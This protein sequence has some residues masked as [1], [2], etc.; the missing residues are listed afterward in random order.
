MNK[1]FV[2][3]GAFLLAVVLAL[4]LFWFNK[5]R[6]LEQY[7][8][9]L[10]LQTATK[11]D[12]HKL[13]I[14]DLETGKIVIFGSSELRY[15]K[16]KFIPQNYFN[17]DLQLP[18]T[19]NGDQGHQCF[20]ILSQLAAY[21]NEKVNKNARVVIFLSPGWVSPR[22]ANGTVIT[23][24][25]KYMNSSMMYQLYFKS[26][27][28]D[29]YKRLIG[30]YIHKNINKITDISFIYKYASNYPNNSDMSK[31]D[32]YFIKKIVQIISSQQST[33]KKIIYTLPNLNYNALREEAKEVAE[34]SD[35]NQF[36]ITNKKYKKHVEPGIKKGNFPFKLAKPPII[37][38][39][40]EY[41]DFLN[42]LKL[43]KRYKIKPLFVMLDIHPYIYSKNRDSMKP[44]LTA[45][46]QEIINNDY[47]YMD[48]WTYDKSKYKIGKLLD[49]WHIGELGWVEVNKKIIEH[50]MAGGLHDK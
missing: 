47:G 39:N 48:M 38:K 6:V 15:T 7:P 4:S 50:F 5:D 19:V 9:L 29:Y 26:N 12:I 25:L 33:A 20:S 11:T 37:G 17:L 44:I 34:L 16:L 23:E 28:D 49:P 13:A 2:N 46:K 32:H 14:S 3:L 31:V 8:S 45:I 24:F 41:K 18:L 27:I 35:N 21:S 30:Q 42:L 36:G 1:F 43:L 22:N 40:Q 10:S